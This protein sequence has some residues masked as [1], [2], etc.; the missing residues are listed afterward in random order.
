M[1]ASTAVKQSDQCHCTLTYMY[2]I[3]IHLYTVILHHYLIVCPQLGLKGVLT[4]LQEHLSTL[5]VD[6]RGEG[7]RKGGRGCDSSTVQLLQVLLHIQNLYAHGYIRIYVQWDTTP[8][9]LRVHE[10]SRH[11]ETK[12]DK[13][14]QHKP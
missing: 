3:H 11:S 14:T 7:E 6:I 8:L 12:K 13:A 2:I 9:E 10:Y 5:E 1:Y 4:E